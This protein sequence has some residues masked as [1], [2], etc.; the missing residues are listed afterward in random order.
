[1]LSVDRSRFNVFIFHEQKKAI[2]DQVLVKF[3]LSKLI[4][5]LSDRANRFFYFDR[6]ISHSPLTLMAGNNLLAA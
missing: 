2:K 3:N 1:M 5:K 4:N 6:A